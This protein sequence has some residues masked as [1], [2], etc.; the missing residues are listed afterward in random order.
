MHGSISSW[1]IWISVSE[2]PVSVQSRSSQLSKNLDAVLHDKD[3]L[4]YFISYLQPLSADNLVRFWLDVEAFRLAA[5]RTTIHLAFP[6]NEEVR[7]TETQTPAKPTKQTPPSTRYKPVEK[8]EVLKDRVQ[9]AQTARMG[10]Q[11]TELSEDVAQVAQTVGI[12]SQRVLT[13]NCDHVLAKQTNQALPSMECSLEVLTGG[14]LVSRMP[15]VP[16]QQRVPTN[17]CGHA[18]SPLTS[19]SAKFTG[20][21][22]AHGEVVVSTDSAI[23]SLGS[24]VLDSGLG[25]SPVDCCLASNPSITQST[26]AG[27]QITEQFSRGVQPPNPSTTQHGTVPHGVE[28]LPG[29][30]QHTV[31]QSLQHGA[32]WKIGEQLSGTEQQTADSLSDDRDITEATS[33]AASSENI[34][35]LPHKGLVFSFHC[36]SNVFE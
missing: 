22:P 12:I 17:Y 18:S 24:A 13:S 20:Q 35:E 6:T 2:T 3:A 11:R 25:R 10:Q 19:S 9:V 21:L 14:V 27:Q 23:P 8:T 26:G 15:E 36:I 5:E 30:G 34:S 7:L 31:A 29:A 28:H 33:S 1:R 16:Q 32:G 4:A